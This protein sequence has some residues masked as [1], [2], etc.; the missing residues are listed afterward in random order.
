MTDA[1]FLREFSSRQWLSARRAVPTRA[2][3]AV[4][5]VKMWSETLINTCLCSDPIDNFKWAYHVLSWCIA[6][7]DCKDVEAISASIPADGKGSRRNLKKCTK[8]GRM[9]QK[10]DVCAPQTFLMNLG[11]G[12]WCEIQWGWRWGITGWIIGADQGTLISYT[13]NKKSLI[14]AA[15]LRGWIPLLMWALEAR[16]CVTH[17][18]AGH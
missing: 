5:Q 2:M 17:W 14:S 7:G 4:W 10:I 16:S 1:K 3:G 6:S 11:A 18:P 13:G 9:S 8:A 12:S 15:W